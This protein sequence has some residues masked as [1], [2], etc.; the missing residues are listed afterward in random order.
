MIKIEHLETFGW[1]AAIRGMR[2]PMNSWGFSDTRFDRLGDSGFRIGHNDRN[3]MNRLV[4]L[5]N[6]HRKFLRMIHVQMDITAPLYWWKQFD[7]Y[8]VGVTSNSCSTMH[9]IADKPFE[10]SD[11][12]LEHVDKNDHALI[13]TIESLNKARDLYNEFVNGNKDFWWHMIQTLPSSYNQKRTI[14]MNYENVLTIV[15]QRTWHKLDEW[16]ELV[17]F[18]RRELPMVDELTEVQKGEI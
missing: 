11:F 4:S 13:E 5:G 7:T 18:F 2:N 3:L 16:N 6:E 17:R 8:K 15:K 10:I 12:S 14:D 9:K 1:E